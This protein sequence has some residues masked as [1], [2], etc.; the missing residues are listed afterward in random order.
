[1]SIK[2]NTKI[3]YIEFK[4]RKR[5]NFFCFSIT[6]KCHSC[7]KILVYFEEKCRSCKKH[8]VHAEILLI[9]AEKITIKAR[10]FCIKLKR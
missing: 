2:V 5:L 8:V 10:I 1:M 6:K 3:N 9:A 4:C 7:R